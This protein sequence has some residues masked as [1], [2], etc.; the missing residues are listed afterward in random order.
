MLALAALSS[1][2]P[3]DTV[4]PSALQLPRRAKIS[5]PSMHRYRH[6]GRKDEW[7]QQLKDVIAA[8]RR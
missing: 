6:L 8:W 4:K 3:I 2:K 5:G 7:W 1:L